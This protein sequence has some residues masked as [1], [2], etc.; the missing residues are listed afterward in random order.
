[1]YIIVCFSLMDLLVF[2]NIVFLD[3]VVNWFFVLFC[4][5]LGE[6]INSFDK[7][8]YGFYEENEFFRDVKNWLKEDVKCFFDIRMKKEIKFNGNKVY[9]LLWEIIFKELLIF[10]VIVSFIYC[11]NKW[12][13]MKREY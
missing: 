8:I 11:L 6:S 5:I 2:L 4:V 9:K 12:K 3:D 10:G 1:M 13:V 7:L